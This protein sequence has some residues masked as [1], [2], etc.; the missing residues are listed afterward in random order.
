MRVSTSQ[1]YN[2]ANIGMRDAQVA[3]DKTNQQI[4]S[5]K[6]VLSPADDPVSATAIL[7]LNQEL[8]R[9]TQFTKNIDTADNNLTLEDTTLQSVVSLVQRLKELA[10]NAGNTAVLTPSDYK[11]MAA[12]VDSR[13]SELMNL[14]NTRNASGQY[15][16]AGFQSETQPFVN[17]GGGNYTY[18]GDEGQLSVQAST[19]VNVAVSDSG[20]RVFVDIPASHNT[21]TTRPSASNQ[22]TPPAVISVGDVYDQAAFDQLFPEDMLVTF[23]ANSAVNPPSPNYT[24]TERS[25]GKVLVEKQVYVSGQDIKVSGAK[26]S[27]SGSPYPG[28][29]AVPS[30]LSLSS[31]AFTGAIAADKDYSVTPG[32]ID[33]TVGGVTETL[34]LDQNMLT[35]SGVSTIPAGLN[36]LITN[37]GGATDKSFYTTPPTNTSTAA[38][39]YKKLQNLGITLSDT[40]VF[41]SPT[42]LN[43]TI[44]NGSSAAIS[45][46]TGVAT[47]GAGTTT[48]NIPISYP[49]ASTFN[50]AATPQTVDI[51]VNGKTATLTLNTS[52]TNAASLA[53]A[54]NNGTNA[55]ELAKLGV[56]A[57]PQGFSS[58][59][60]SV[61]SLSNAGSNVLAAMGVSGNPVTSSL[62][63]LAQP[64]DKFV[65]ES[66][67]KQALLTTV[68]R[69]SEAMKNVDSTQTSKD[70]FS[71]LVAKTLA[72]LENVLGNISAVQ[73]DVGARQNMLESTRNLNSDIELNSKTVLSQMEDLDYAEASTRLQMQTFVL[74]AAQQSFIRISDLNLFKYM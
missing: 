53:A 44:K 51:T 43:I 37:L 6:R 13:L 57:T 49:G 4:S 66:T 36:D 23:N 56:I 67:G 42:G 15:I 48:P 2:I 69:F 27:I 60:N 21:F 35:N 47:Q 52:V 55:I 45:N 26:F 18:Q 7:M 16:F 19:T 20:K 41:T 58:L 24:I 50:F 9:T 29:A 54:F 65:V 17:N 34:K 46:I 25:T 64:G 73:G 68:S 62:G 5:G 30:T 40:G 1:I 74:S 71:K 59:N 12:E 38:A 39:N 32:Y 70:E 31:A 72:S 33:I 8:A 10:V 11:S 3:V 63:V 61:I 14:Q 22:A 28:V